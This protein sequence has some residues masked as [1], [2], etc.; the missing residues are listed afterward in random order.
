MNQRL[1]NELIK[2]E[3]QHVLGEKSND[4]E[5]S[6]RVIE[7]PLKW[8]LSNVVTPYLQNDE[9][10]LLIGNDVKEEVEAVKHLSKVT[11]ASEGTLS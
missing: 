9:H 3:K 4:L 7:F 10:L 5:K 8:K 2:E 1:F 11:V 6:R